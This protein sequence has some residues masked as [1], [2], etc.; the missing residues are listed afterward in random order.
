MK[1][2]YLEKANLRETQLNMATVGY[3]KKC[4]EIAN[5]LMTCTVHE[6]YQLIKEISEVSDAYKQLEE[7][8]MDYV[9]KYQEEA[10]KDLNEKG[11]NADA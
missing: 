4:H 2:Y 11:E 8:Y 10:L 3:A 1:Q 6:S 5:K 7:D 9:K